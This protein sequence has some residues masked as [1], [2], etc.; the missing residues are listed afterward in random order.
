MFS[1]LLTQG[2]SL[3]LIV[4]MALPSKYLTWLGP[5]SFGLF[6]IFLCATCLL[7]LLV[8]KGNQLTVQVWKA[9]IAATVYVLFF[10]LFLISAH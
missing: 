5:R 2:V 4:A 9:I 1:L 10:S 7:A 3:F 8:A 6:D